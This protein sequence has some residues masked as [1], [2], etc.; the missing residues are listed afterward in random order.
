[1]KVTELLKETDKTHFTIEILPPLKGRGID[2]L[3]NI[4]DPLME[5]DP[6]FI[7]VTYHREEYVY[8]SR[9]HGLLEKVP[10]RKRPGTIG[11]CAAIQ[12]KYK[13]DTV[14]HLICGGFTK[15][16]TEDALVDLHYLGIQNVLAL[17]GDALH[18]EKNF[19]PEEGGNQYAVDLI[20][21]IMDM[22]R[23][24][25]LD[26]DLSDPLKTDFCIGVA[27]YPE[28]H[29]EAPN[30]QTDLKYLKLK[31]ERGASYI[32]TQMFFDNKKYFQFVRNCRE[33]GINVPI[34]PGIKPLTSF[35]QVRSLPSSF[36]ID[37][38]EELTSELEKCKDNSQ[39]RQ[40]GIEWCIQQ[41]KELVDFGVPC[42]HFYTMSR[43]K[44]TIAVAREIF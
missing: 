12:N 24:E 23:G 30:M 44:S 34:I 10:V 31:V 15:Q 1:M 20:N 37:L 18:S 41:C 16:S 28:K 6:K 39:V 14:P 32:V 43:Y 19:N 40:V 8:K 38:P 9:G 26:E 35:K 25:Y 3:Y 42:L 33:M 11:I 29:F 36:F 22:N 7:D 13:V 21:Q 5:F 27:G 2:E 4:L 17:R